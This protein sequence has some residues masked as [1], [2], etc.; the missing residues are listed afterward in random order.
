MTV[1]LM[2]DEKILYVLI[3]GES[4]YYKTHREAAVTFNNRH[5][6]RNINQSRFTKMINK[7]KSYGSIHNNFNKKTFKTT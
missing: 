1:V 5:P 7:F 2:C 6:N 3:V 4:E